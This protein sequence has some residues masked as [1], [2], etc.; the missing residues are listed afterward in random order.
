MSAWAYTLGALLAVGITAAGFLFI[1]LF[2]YPPTVISRLFAK[3][4]RNAKLTIRL[5]L[6]TV[7][8]I[9]CGYIAYAAISRL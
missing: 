3:W 1:A 2:I 4:G 6:A 8:L 7:M 5:S 9:G